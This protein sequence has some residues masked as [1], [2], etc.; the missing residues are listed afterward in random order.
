MEKII[1][2]SIGKSDFKNFWFSVISGSSCTK[3]TPNTFFYLI[4]TKNKKLWSDYGR[5]RFYE[6]VLKIFGFLKSV[7]MAPFGQGVATPMH[8]QLNTRSLFLLST[9]DIMFKQRNIK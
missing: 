5:E 7:A 2:F 6:W 1:L 3:M 4:K 9:P 8:S